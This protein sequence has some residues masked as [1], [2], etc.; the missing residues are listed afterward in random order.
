MTDEADRPAAAATMFGPVTAPLVDFLIRSRWEDIPE[1]VRHAA[2]RSILNIFGTALGGSRN[3]ATECALRVLTQFSARPEASVVGRAE[4]LDCL[5]AAYLN[6]VSANVFDFD[7]THLRTII[8]PTAPVAPALF[9]LAE[10]RPM[11][12]AELLHAFVLGV[13]IECRL[14]NAISPGHYKRGWHITSTCGVFGSAAAIGKVMGLDAERMGWALG[15]ASAQSAGLVETLGSMAK[16]I[17]VGNAA[18]GG[19]LAALLAQEGATGPFEPIAGPRG[20]L[21]VMGDMPDFEAVTGRLGESWEVLDNIHKPYPCGVVLNPV[22]DACLELRSR[23]LPLN[24]IAEIRIE[25]H[26][27]LRE[28]A[29][30][31]NVT[32]GREAQVSAQHT[33]AAVLIHGAAGVAQYEDAC[34]NSADVLALRRKVVVVE[35]SGIPVESA[36]VTATLDDG[37][38]VASFVENARGTSKRPLTDAEIGAKLRELAHYACPG[39]DTAPLI[40]AVWRL[41][42]M[43]NAADIMQLARID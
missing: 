40:D 18:R 8:H 14:G 41:D 31:P 12:G 15:N 35:T 23:D 33:V 17:G 20:F 37:T 2:K 3:E 43:Q 34:V 38:Q 5:S 11:S 9:A 42:Q 25:G 29:D 10:R 39:Y 1:S 4:R 24:R 13:E 22:I 28:R 36:R 19:M 27:L 7:D 30:R 32:A 21:H 26:S 16:S 6:A